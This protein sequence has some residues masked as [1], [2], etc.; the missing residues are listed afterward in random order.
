MQGKMFKN[1]FLYRRKKHAPQGAGWKNNSCVRRKFPTLLLCT[2][3]FN[4]KRK[5]YCKMAD[6]QSSRL[7]SQLKVHART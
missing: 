4:F 3:N 6:L 2:T 7:N 1:I 5:N